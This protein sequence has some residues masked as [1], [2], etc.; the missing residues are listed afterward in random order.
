VLA[1]AGV[2]KPILNK[3]SRDIANVLR[4]PDVAEKMKAQGLV[5]ATQTPD[6]FDAL[7]RAEAERYGRILRDAGVG[8]N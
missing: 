7:V 8:A 3:I 4:L 2:P 5:V 6:E 1:P